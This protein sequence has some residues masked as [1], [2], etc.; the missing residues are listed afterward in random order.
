M[1]AVTRGRDSRPGK[2]SEG[3]KPVKLW[4]VV[5]HGRSGKT[6]WASP[7]GLTERRQA[8]ALRDELRNCREQFNARIRYWGAVDP[9]TMQRIE[10]KRRARRE[11]KQG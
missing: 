7:V 1:V 2:G 5:I 4:Y 10:R 6:F 9:E 11:E 3:V 8:I